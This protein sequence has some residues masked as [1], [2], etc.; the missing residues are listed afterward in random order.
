MLKIGKSG[1][2][3][4]CE[5]EQ[6]GAL[7]MDGLGLEGGP[8]LGGVLLGDVCRGEKPGGNLGEILVW[9]TW[10]GGDK[11]ELM[12]VVVLA[13]VWSSSFGLCCKDSRL[14]TF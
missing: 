13:I 3:C 5:G 12:F 7:A 11:L 14:E 2:A 10:I 9:R 6:L 4:A 8:L 1:G